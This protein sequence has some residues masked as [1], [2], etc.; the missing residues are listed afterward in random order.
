MRKLLRNLEHYYEEM[1]ALGDLSVETLEADPVPAVTD[2]RILNVSIPLCV[3]H[4]FDDPIAT[5]RGN[6]ENFGLLHPAN[7]V[8]VGRGNILLLFTKKDMAEANPNPVSILTRIYKD[9]CEIC[10][11]STPIILTL[12]LS[13]GIETISMYFIG[14]IGEEKQ[15]AAVG[16]AMSL[17]NVVIMT[18]LYQFSRIF[19]DVMR[20][21]IRWAIR[22]QLGSDFDV[23]RHFEPT[24]DPWD[25]RLCI[26]P[27]GDFFQALK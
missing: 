8:R 24:Y 20:A 2:A 12:V 7:L 15:I 23:D 21:L 5:W 22:W 3:L 4:S 19:P 18:M 11:L 13:M 9:T 25:Q 26:A 1:G 16:V 6:A 10:F 27:D 14:K 17:I